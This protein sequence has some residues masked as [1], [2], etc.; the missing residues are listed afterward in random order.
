V[1]R[2]DLRVG[3]IGFGAVG[4]P[5]AQGILEGLAGCCQLAAVLVRAKSLDGA[6]EALPAGCLVT[7]DLH[8]FLGAAPDVVVETA[9]HEALRAYGR[10]VLAA[11]KDLVTISA[12]ALADDLFRED[13]IAAAVANG[14]RILVPSGAIAGLDGIGAAALI[15]KTEVTHVTRKPAAAWR[16]TA[17]EQ[18]VDLDRLTGPVTLLEGS[19]RQSAAVYPTNVNVQAAVAMAGIGL[20]STRVQAVADPA[21]TGNVHEITA[22]GD[23]GEFTVTVRGV[24]TPGNAKTGKLTAFSVLRTVRNLTAPLVIGV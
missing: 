12:G 2:K 19:A 10:A 13:L 8:A 1:L 14:S 21:A 11:G 18:Q 4:A 17:A 23:F 15:P 9:G 6:R 5:V 16:G 24:P 22:R 3:L 20:D 7:A